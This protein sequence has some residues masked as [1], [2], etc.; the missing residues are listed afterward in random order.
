MTIQNQENAVWYRINCEQNLMKYIV[1]KG[2]VA[3]DG[4]SLTVAKVEEQSFA[5]SIIPHTQAET[6]LRYKNRGDIL[7][8]ECDIIGKYVEKLLMAKEKTS[9]LTEEFLRENGF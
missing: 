3:L 6:N 7:N 1:E 9:K 5:V 8:I 2:S 4:I